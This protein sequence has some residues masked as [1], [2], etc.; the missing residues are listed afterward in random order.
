[1]SQPL[2][3]PA[4]VDRSVVSK[5]NQTLSYEFRV[6]EH[7][8]DEGKV[9]AYI[10][11]TQVWAHDPPDQYSGHRRAPILVQDWTDVPRV[12]MSANP[13]PAPAA[14]SKATA[15]RLTSIGSAG[16]WTLKPTG[17]IEQYDASYKP[18]SEYM[19]DMAEML[20]EDQNGVKKP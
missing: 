16:S 10:M 7:V 11:Q 18:V 17:Y 2:H 15:Q 5:Q 12:R 13:N 9:T 19:K 20:E 14:F 8:N 6:V 1:M 3:I 4:V